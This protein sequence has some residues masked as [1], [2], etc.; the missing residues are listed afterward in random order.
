MA[1]N[2][3]GG[4]LQPCSTDPLTGFLPQRLLRHRR[5]GHR[6][7]HGVRPADR[8]VP[9]VQP[10]GWGNDLSTPRPEYGFR[11]AETG[12]TSGA[13]ARPGGPR[14]WR[15]GV[16]RRSYWRPRTPTRWSGS[17][18]RTCASTQSSRASSPP[19]WVRLLDWPAYDPPT[20]PEEARMPG[21]DTP[22]GWTCPRP[23]STTGPSCPADPSCPA[24]RGSADGGAVRALPRGIKPLLVLAK[25]REVLRRSPSTG[26]SSPCRRS[27][28]HRAAGEHLPADRGEPG[29]R[30]LLGPGGGQV[31]DRG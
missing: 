2:V 26:P 21:V 30:G 15:P 25:I 9:R 31:P 4:E 24:T 11:R 27:G 8:G 5:G 6:R 17:T 14:R 20:P 23:T 22:T 10:G 3:L 12:A 28:A 16:P 1:H 7:A 19:R 18:S 29:R 13:C